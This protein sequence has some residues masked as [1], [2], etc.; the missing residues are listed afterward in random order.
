[1]TKITID[2]DLI[3]TQLDELYDQQARLKFELKNVE[4][5]ID[6]REFKLKALLDDLQVN[7]MMHNSYSF[8]WTEKTINRL[9]QSMLKEK[10]PQQ[11]EECYLPS[12]SKVFKF[13]INK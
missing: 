12:V 10:Y 13:N 7:E 8:G 4:K 6:K 11:Y 1:M 5:E 2:L 3:T 9:N